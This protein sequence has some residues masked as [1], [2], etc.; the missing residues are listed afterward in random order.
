MQRRPSAPFYRGS[1][2]DPGR[3]AHGGAAVR[4]RHR[5]RRRR[6]NRRT[7]DSGRRGTP[8]PS[9]SLRCSAQQSRF[10]FAA[11]FGRRFRDM[12]AG[13]LVTAT[14]QL[15]VSTAML[16]PLFLAV[17]RPW[18]LPAPGWESGAAVAG[19]APALDCAGLHPLF[20]HPGHGRRDEPASG[21]PPDP[22]YC[23]S[24]GSR[25]PRRKAGR[26]ALCWHGAAGLRPG[27]IDGRVRLRRLT[28]RRH[29]GSGVRT[30][31]AI[32]GRSRRCSTH[33][34]VQ[35]PAVRRGA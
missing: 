35:L 3:K 29:S 2:S 12:G 4:D 22:G 9:P 5:L 6:G 34:S 1:F 8:T 23:R 28:G 31:T 20:S 15:T 18:S 10:A 11:V 33:S 25:R 32:F 14:G 26:P 16:V 21:D 27:V 13:P 24:S 17:D 7:G 19:L 30:M